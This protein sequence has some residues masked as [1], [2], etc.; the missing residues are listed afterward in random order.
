MEHGF[1]VLQ[2]QKREKATERKREEGLWL[3]QE[4]VRKVQICASSVSLGSDAA[5]K[6]TESKRVHRQTF[7]DAHCDFFLH[8]WR[9]MSRAA[10]GAEGRW[11]L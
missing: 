3:I 7:T 11:C 8:G 5:A 6:Q 2:R 10:A 9:Y 1:T 4:A